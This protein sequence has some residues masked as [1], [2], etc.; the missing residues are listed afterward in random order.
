VRRAEAAGLVYHPD[1]SL[2]YL[3]DF[4]RVYYESMDYRSAESFYYF[5]RDYFESIRNDLADYAFLS[6]AS[7]DGEMIAGM[8]FLRDGFYAHSHLSGSA[9]E[10]RV[11][12]PNHFVV[13]KSM[14]E[15]AEQGCRL[16]HLGGGVS[17]NK[18]DGLYRFKGCFSRDRYPFHV[19]STMFD[20]K[21]YLD[22][23]FEWAERSFGQQASATRFPAYGLTAARS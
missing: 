21:A 13:Y 15:L 20:E 12:S 10:G 11:H 3:D 19:A 6:M 9:V 14:L 5:D 4:M 22:A 17:S 8:L 16:L 7:L 1:P 18:D 2:E 23:A